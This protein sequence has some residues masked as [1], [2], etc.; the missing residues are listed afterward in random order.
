MVKNL[1]AVQET[2]IQSLGQ[3]DPLEKGMATHSSILAWRIPWTQE[4]GR[5]QS[6]GLQRV[7]MTDT[8]TF[9]HLGQSLHVKVLNFN[10][11]CK[12]PFASKV[13]YSQA[14]GFGPSLSGT[15]VKGSAYQCRRYKRFRFIPWVGKIPGKGHDNNSSILAWKI[16]WT[17]EPNR[18]HSIGSQW[19]NTT[20]HAHILLSTEAMKLGLY[21]TYTHFLM[22]SS[23]P[24]DGISQ[25]SP[26]LC[27]QALTFS[28]TPGPFILLTPR[29]LH[30]TA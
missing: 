26:N 3:E 19:V 15:V 11:I 21:S 8:F 20:E 24:V 29:H 1:P 5:L 16:P 7:R 6:M 13:T 18:L 22:I 14:L 30:L 9:I 23:K 10:H 25:W 12:I 2:R 27:L 17:K 4:P 28:Q